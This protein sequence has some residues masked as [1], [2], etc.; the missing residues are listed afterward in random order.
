MK[1][2]IASP[3]PVIILVKPQM[4]ENIGMC[5]RAMLNCGVTEMR[6]VAPRDGWPNEKA[7]S[8]A[9]GASSIIE[10]AKLYNTTKEAVADLEFVIAT[11]ARSRDM[12]KNIYTPETAA[13]EIYNRISNLQKCG[14]IFGPERAGLEN[15]DIA[16]SDAVLNIPLNPNFSSLNLAQGVLLVS[17]ALL[18]AN[19]TFKPKEVLKE[20][21]PAKKENIELLLEHLE[22][23]LDKNNFFRTKEKK[24]NTLLN[25]RNFFFR[26]APTEQETRTLRGIISSLAGKRNL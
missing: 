1:E 7:I 22:T 9:S 18:T 26:A 11:T 5:A 16:L 4:G 15:N 14:I 8:P 6:L 19:K 2:I 13:I 12:V 3:A 17:F 20:N 23:E 10:N 24:P 25:I 21:T